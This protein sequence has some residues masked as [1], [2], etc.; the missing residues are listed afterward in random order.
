MHEARGS[1][2]GVCQALALGGAGWGQLMREGM[3]IIRE[4]GHRDSL[5]L[6]PLPSRHL[7][8]DSHAQLM[9]PGV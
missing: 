2:G 9:L 6:P 8:N 7:A 3:L 4:L 5:F 1:W